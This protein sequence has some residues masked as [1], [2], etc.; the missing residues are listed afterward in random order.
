MLNFYQ[1]GWDSRR[2]E[3]FVLD[4]LNAGLALPVEPEGSRRVKWAQKRAKEGTSQDG[5]DVI[6]ELEGG[7]RWGIQC[8]HYRKLTLSQARAIVEEVESAEQ[9]GEAAQ[10]HILAVACEV[11]KEVQ[12]YFLESRHW[13]L[14]TSSTLTSFL[15]VKVLPREKA[16]TV[17]SQHFGQECVHALFPLHDKILLSGESYFAPMRGQGDLFHH[18]T[19]LVGRSAAL[20]RIEGF[21]TNSSKKVLII[22]A[23]G[24]EG[25][26]RLLVEIDA[27]FPDQFPDKQLR[28]VN[29]RSSNVSV[30]TSMAEIDWGSA[31]IVQDDA[32][33]IDSLRPEIIREI[34]SHQTAKL[35][36]ATRP[37]VVDVLR[38]QLLEHGIDATHVESRRLL[39]LKRKEMQQLAAAVLGHDLPPAAAVSL[40]RWSEQSPLICTIGGELLKRKQLQLNEVADEKDFQYHVFRRFEKANLDRCGCPEHFREDLA[41]LLKVVALLSPVAIDE[42]FFAG[43]E[44]VFGWPRLHAEDC[45]SR[46]KATELLMPFGEEIRIQPDLLSDH[47]AFTASVSDGE[48]SPL[49]R[50]IMVAFNSHWPALLQNLS[51]AEWRWR[52][53]QDL[54]VD[55]T[56][57][58][59]DVFVREFK[60]SCFRE[61][62]SMIGKWARFAVYQPKRSLD[63]V[64]LALKEKEAPEDPSEFLGGHPFYSYEAL[65]K[66]LSSIIVPV[67]THCDEFREPAL[68]CLWRLSKTC[69]GE[70]ANL[71]EELAKIIRIRPGWRE[72]RALQVI[73]WVDQLLQRP[74]ESWLLSEHCQFLNIVLS[75]VFDRVTEEVC[76]DDHS[77][78]IATYHRSPRTWEKLRQRVFRLL[79]ER[80][81]LHSPTAARNVVSL[82]SVGMR[83]VAAPRGEA[84]DVASRKE[85]KAREKKR[86]TWRSE[87]LQALD[88]LKEMAE[89]HRDP[90][91]HYAVHQ[92]LKH[93][94][95]YEEDVAFRDMVYKVD[96]LLES[97]L[98]FD[99]CRCV[100][101][102]EDTEF[103]E[104]RR[105]GRDFHE[106]YE[107]AVKAYDEFVDS[108][109]EK[110]FDKLKT[111]ELW[112]CYVM[113]FSNR[114]A[115]FGY[116]QLNWSPVIRSVARQDEDL[117]ES[118]LDRVVADA[119]SVFARWVTPLLRFLPE[120]RRIDRLSAILESKD[121]R[122]FQ[123]ALD[124]LVGSSHSDY[125]ENCWGRL[126][127]WAEHG[128]SGRQ[129]ALVRFAADHFYTDATY[130]L[131]LFE[132]LP[133]EAL[134]GITMSNWAG[135]LQGLPE[136]DLQWVSSSLWSKVCRVLRHTRDLSHGNVEQLLLRLCKLQPRMVYDLCVARIERGV[137][138]A[139]KEGRKDFVALPY[140]F[141]HWQ[142]PGI[143]E[144]PS[145]SKIA[146]ELLDRIES[147]DEG[148]YYWEQLFWVAV[149]KSSSQGVAMLME[150]V[151]NAG[152]AEEVRDAIRLIARKGSLFVFQQPEFVKA[153]LGRAS[154]FSADDASEI[155]WHLLMSVRQDGRGYTAGELDPEH[156]Y[157]LEEA[158]KAHSKH[159]DDGVLEKFYEEIISMEEADRE[160]AR[161][162]FEKDWDHDPINR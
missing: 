149:I 89:I 127:Y 58:L 27:R 105:D 134:D 132:R 143:D 150:R 9:V 146:G 3:T 141:E 126:F 121:E 5:V 110:L 112:E 138:L 24:G 118:F 125:P 155:R 135:I 74:G 113:E 104:G 18:G 140:R 111:T 63:L 13:D 1:E 129:R 64:E 123:S 2:F 117:A 83:R 78:S 108:T 76:H 81:F 101:G 87:R 88:A 45:V 62:I 15:K 20:E 26:S 86:F 154:E 35:I 119:D 148:S 53:Q 162:R 120:K 139:E 93:L 72:E 57:S 152:K 14:W 73:E 38:D 91:L 39:P 158:R 22:K 54:A 7:H 69:P 42:L 12:D 84:S 41:K 40:A 8:K 133:D 11:T 98:D 68:G 32:H 99:L 67:A 50:E 100:I 30:A 16:A 10:H 70:A 71:W 115:L 48:M 49:C 36:I 147:G 94:L 153:A 59:W 66:A 47:L 114:A 85:A 156:H 161:R 109:T 37:Q 33:R 116:S 19:T 79:R 157:I 4:L 130:A 46:L 124:V 136:N 90:I 34:A 61:R 102:S 25:K 28:F 60:E 128:D 80:V 142:F 107:R 55:L 31:V 75:P 145:F 43:L 122:L 92:E 151:N 17:A 29:P 160:S 77:I 96:Q 97:S 44:G 21:I 103:M 144:D 52:N 137:T 6:A 65:V 106:R 56:S 23:R 51:A 82:L 159:R 131:E 95:D